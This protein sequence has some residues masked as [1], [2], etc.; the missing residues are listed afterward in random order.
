MNSNA[1][2]DGIHHITAIASSAEENL[3]FYRNVLGLRFV[4]KTVNFDD[5]SAYHL[6]YGDSQGSPGTIVTFFPWEKLPRG[7]NGAGL[8]DAIAFSIPA[9]AVPYWHGRLK[10]HGIATQETERFGDRAIRFQDPH[11]LFLEL[12]A[13]PSARPQAVWQGSRVPP[14]CGIVGC[15]SAT[16]RLHSLEETGYLLTDVLGMTFK[17]RE[18]H[19]HRFVMNRP[20]GV[21]A[22]YDVLV[23]DRSPAA[24][25]GTGTVHHIAFRT[26]SSDE[27]AYWRNL[28]LE[29]KVSVTPVIDRKYFTSI[30]FREPNGVLFEIATDSPGFTVDEPFERLG[31][32]L[33]LPARLEGMRTEIENQLPRL[34]SL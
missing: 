1:T 9:D 30:Y 31:R 10:D 29:H 21:G 11:G 16:Q 6:Y 34:P 12:I 20:D 22:F 13:T 3:A 19:R 25:P 7:R 15:H 17:D 32:D 18:D 23:D 4:K 24:R 14:E 5:P 2:I 33:Q 27:Q 8:V 28:L 26:P